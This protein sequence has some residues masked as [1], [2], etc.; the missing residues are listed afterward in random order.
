MT[1]PQNALVENVAAGSSQMGFWFEIR[2]RGSRSWKMNGINILEQPMGRFD[3]NVAHSCFSHGLNFYLNGYEP[4]TLQKLSNL[5]IFRNYFRGVRLHRVRNLKFSHCTFADQATSIVMD[6]S[7]EIHVE[8]SEVIGYSTSYQM[9]V[10]RRKLPL[11]RPCH[12][13]DLM[14]DW[15]ML[16]ITM[17]S[18][19]PWPTRLDTSHKGL[20]LANVRFR[21]FDENVCKNP[22]AFALERGGISYQTL[23]TMNSFRGIS[24]DRGTVDLCTA[25]VDGTDDF[26]LTDFGGTTGVHEGVTKQ[27]TL[28]MDSERMLHFVDRSKCSANPERCYAFC[29]GVCFRTI[30]FYLPLGGTEQYMLR[31]CSLQLGT[32][33]YNIPGTVF[34]ESYPRRF[35]AHIPKGKYQLSFVRGNGDTTLPP[36]KEVFYATQDPSCK[37]GASIDDINFPGV[38]MVNKGVGY[39]EMKNLYDPPSD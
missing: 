4:K 17:Q 20:V 35:S 23:E 28:V 26:Y 30:N 10:R 32:S 22:V 8:S 21:D 11:L 27:G 13:W 6:R 37:N 14:R 7:E 34:K 9:H 12:R 25:K 31:V 38:T 2:V 16:G 29:E 33:C 19:N 39:S 36:F 15:S 1:N 5:R 18:E 3:G 24:F